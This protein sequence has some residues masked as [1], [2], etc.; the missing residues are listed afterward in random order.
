MNIICPECNHEIIYK[1]NKY[2]TTCKCLFVTKASYS[3][4]LW[5]VRGVSSLKIGDDYFSGDYNFYLNS[6]LKLAQ[7]V[8]D[9]ELDRTP[10]LLTINSLKLKSSQEII[11]KLYSYKKLQSFI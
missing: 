9:S 10:I 8:Y 1:F 5:F 7:F 2:C 4:Y 3:Y 11:N 6:N